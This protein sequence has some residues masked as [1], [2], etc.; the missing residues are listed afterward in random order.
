MPKL[1][2][3]N[4]CNNVLSTGKIAGDIG[5]L[6]VSCGWNSCIISSKASG[7]LPSKSRPILIG[8]RFSRYFHALETRIFDNHSLGLSSRNATKKAINQIEIIRPDIIHLHII[9][10]YYLNLPILFDF[11]ANKDIPIVWTIHS[12]WEFTGHCAFFDRVGCNKWETG[13]SNC[14]QLKAYPTSWLCDRSRKNYAEKK[15]IFTSLKNVTLVPV[16]Y[17]L[18]GLLQKSFLKGYSIRPIYNG[19]DVDKF[20]PVADSI[21]IKRRFVDDHKFLAIGVASTWEERKNLSDFIR[22]SESLSEEYQIMLIGL[23][24]K[25]IRKLPASIIGLRRTTDFSELVGLYSAA[26]V[27]LNLSLEETFGLTTVEGFACG[28]P[29]IVYNKTASPELVTPETGFVV[30]AGDID[31]IVKCM[32]EIRA[33][34]KSYYS[35]SCRKRAV[36]KFDKNKNFQQYID[37]YEELLRRED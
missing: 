24:Q 3:I 12:C 28:T 31:G 20:R 8:G 22:L 33:K 17:W 14:P 21:S 34:G 35:E 18:G 25:Q 26:D 7:F 30:D 2:Q 16:S 9:H 13:C 5:E 10:G 19:V 6:A 15:K 23:S 4:E 32:E 27:V 29:S 1:L 36:E 37:L 11:L